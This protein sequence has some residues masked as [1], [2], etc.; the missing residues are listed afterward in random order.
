M[1]RCVLLDEKANVTAG[2]TVGGEIL[3]GLKYIYCVFVL[4][5]DGESG[6]ICFFF[7]IC[8]AS[9]SARF[10]TLFFICGYLAIFVRVLYFR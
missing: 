6:L 9:V 10:F 5:Q 1:F 8:L 3:I 7:T 2:S 4:I